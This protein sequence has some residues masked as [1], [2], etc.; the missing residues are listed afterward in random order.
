MWLPF[1]RTV[2]LSQRVVIGLCI[3]QFPRLHHFTFFAMRRHGVTISDKSASSTACVGLFYLAFVPADDAK[4]SPRLK[5]GEAR[6]DGSFC[7]ASFLGR[8]APCVYVRVVCF[9]SPCR[10]ISIA[11]NTSWAYTAQRTSSAAKIQFLSLNGFQGEGAGHDR[12]HAAGII[13][14]AFDDDLQCAVCR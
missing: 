1:V 8:L 11:R 2:R 5:L 7:T 6:S 9:K 4:D 10:M 13:V 12:E 3:V 14:L